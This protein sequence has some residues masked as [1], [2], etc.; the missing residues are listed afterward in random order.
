MMGF[1]FQRR[2]YF[3]A[4]EMYLAYFLSRQMKERQRHHQSLR[5]VR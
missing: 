5:L 2:R 4:R 3:L 1:H